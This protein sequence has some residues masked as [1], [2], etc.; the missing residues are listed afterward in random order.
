ADVPLTKENVVKKAVKEASDSSQARDEAARRL[1]TTAEEAGV[2]LKDIKSSTVLTKEAAQQK[3]RQAVQDTM[4]KRTGHAGNDTGLNADKFQTDTL[5][6]FIDQSEK[7]LSEIF[8]NDHM[9]MGAERIQSIQRVFDAGFGDAFDEKQLEALRRGT[10]DLELSHQVAT[11]TVLV[12]DFLGTD[13]TITMQLMAEVTPEEMPKVL[14]KSRN[15]LIRGYEALEQTKKYTFKAGQAL[16][17]AGITHDDMSKALADAGV[18]DDVA[19]ESAETI[20][21][22]QGKKMTKAQIDRMTLESAK[23]IVSEMDKDEILQLAQSIKITNANGGRITD[24]LMSSLRENN[25]LLQTQ[26]NSMWRKMT[27][28]LIKYRYFAMLCGVKTQAKNLIGD[29]LKFGLMMVEE[30]IKCITTGIAGGFKDKGFSG[31]GVGAMNGAKES[32][33]FYKGLYYGWDITAEHIA[34]AW[35]YAEAISHV[36]E[37]GNLLGNERDSALEAIAGTVFEAPFK[38]LAAIDDGFAT[39]LAAANS[40]QRAMKDLRASG[41][42]AKIKDAGKRKDFVDA[43]IESSF[44]RDFQETILDDGKKMR[45]GKIATEQGKE[46]AAEGTFQQKLGQTMESFIKWTNSNP[47]L[48]I[49]FPFVRTPANLLK[50]VFITRGAGMPFEFVAAMR[51]GDPQQIGKAMTHLASGA[52][53]WYTAYNMAA[54]GKI[55]GNGPTNKVARDAL[56]ANGWQPHS[57][58]MGDKY[59]QLATI[60]P[61]GSAFEVMADW[62]EKIDRGEITDGQLE[63]LLDCLFAFAANR[64]YFQGLTSLLSDMKYN[65]MMDVGGFVAATVT[66]FAPAF[67]TEMSRAIDPVIYQQRDILSTINKSIGNTALLEPK[68]SWITGDPLVYSS[69]GGLGAFSPISKTEDHGNR[70]FGE[71][72]KVTNVG[73][74]SRIIG[75]HRLDDTEYSRYCQLIGTTTINGKTLYESLDELVTSDWYDI[76]RTYAEDPSVNGLSKERNKAI[77]QV[78]DAYKEQAEREITEELGLEQSDYTPQMPQPFAAITDF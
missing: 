2:D 12:E 21:K 50:D 60:E 17:A 71:L 11:W 47:A 1:S 67:A 40:Y 26:E 34:N 76:D 24:L 46:I 39:S 30:P 7:P 78:T 53:L 8:K 70:V 6:A 35:K 32:I 42:L 45:L 66:S 13:L 33:D 16:R 52:A 5:R 55:T 18:F 56:Y 51:T 44:M 27:K 64:T 41:V 25:K 61:W 73:D 49:V 28:S 72:S 43:F 74:P 58:K 77:R 10:A 19:T 38:A 29:S 62:F 9:D 14:E 15:L 63:P 65:R 57:F 22:A 3:E 4:R 20:S 36:S 68:R 37:V 23:D 48:K 59:I 31:I 69:N 75:S 54:E